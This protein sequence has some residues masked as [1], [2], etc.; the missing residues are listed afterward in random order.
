MFNKLCRYMCVH[1]YQRLDEINKWHVAE[2]W[3]DDEIGEESRRKG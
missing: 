2:K 1:L 3:H